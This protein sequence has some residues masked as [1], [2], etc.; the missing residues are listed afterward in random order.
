VFGSVSGLCQAEGVELLAKSEGAVAE[1]PYLF[2]FIEGD[3]SAECLR[4]NVCKTLH[5]LPF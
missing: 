3:R 5:S 4:S 2:M 1:I